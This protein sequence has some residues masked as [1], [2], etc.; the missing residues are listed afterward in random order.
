MSRQQTIEHEVELSGRGLFT[1]Y[2]V[3]LRFKPAAPGSGVTFVRADQPHPIR[4][5][6]RIDNL[7]KRARRTSLRNGSVSIETVE[8]CLA[9]VR[10]LHQPGIARGLEVVAQSPLGG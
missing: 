2:P 5:P 4:I 9:A 8:H 6:A 7:T 1:G 3:N 10:G